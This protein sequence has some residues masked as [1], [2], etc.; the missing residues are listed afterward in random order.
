MKKLIKK[1]FL[2]ARFI[3]GVYFKDLM[4][5]FKKIFSTQEKHFSLRDKYIIETYFFGT[6]IAVNRL[7]SYFNKKYKENDHFNFNGILLP[8]FKSYESK[9][10]L[11]LTWMDFIYPYLFDDYSDSYREGPYLHKNVQIEEGG[12]VIDAGAN[13]GSFSALAAFLGGVVY[14]FEPVK[15]IREKYLVK[16]AEL[17]KNIF[18]VSYGL[19]NKKEF[20]NIKGDNMTSATITIEGQ[21]NVKN[22][23]IDE[24]VQV[25]TLDEWVKKNSIPRI[26]FIKA[27]IEGAERLMLEGAQWTLKTFSPQLSI[28]TYHLPD[29]KEVLSKLILQANP[30]YKIE[31]RWKKL[32]AWV[33]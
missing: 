1:E 22:N 14:A 25:I 20:I 2:K 16:T 17:N 18:L 3:N 9:N 19:S 33:E 27:D 26:D 7:Y 13:V 30:N 15:E 10:A 28:C 21:R 31:H 4:T 11:I 8:D 12:I 23:I 32:Y 6:K 24:H 5:V 29:D